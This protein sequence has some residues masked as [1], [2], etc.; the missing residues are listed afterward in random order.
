MTVT[1]STLSGNSAGVGSGGGIDNSGTVMVTNSTLSGNSV[2]F[3]PNNN[4]GGIANSGT[5]TVID[6]TLSGNSAPAAKAE[7]SPTGA[8]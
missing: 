6:S 7:A 3:G 5:L 1:D 2:S 8:C 4:G